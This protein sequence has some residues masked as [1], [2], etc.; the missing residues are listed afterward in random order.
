MNINWVDTFTFPAY[1]YTTDIKSALARNQKLVHISSNEVFNCTNQAFIP[2]LYYHDPKTPE[3]REE[4]RRE[5]EIFNSGV[6]FLLIRV[7]M[8]LFGY[9]CPSMIEEIAEWNGGE[10]LKLSARWAGTPTYSTDVV[11]IIK[12][13]MRQGAVGIYHVANAGN[14]TEFSWGNYVANRLGKPEAVVPLDPDEKT[15][16]IHPLLD[17]EKVI[18]DVGFGIPKWTNAIDRYI[19]ARELHV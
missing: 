8:W 15:D 1:N 12:Y 9:S 7:P 13:L 5:L 4:V 18:K 6:Q 3:G 16:Y 14:A 17:I 19:E 11:M 2:E 10:P